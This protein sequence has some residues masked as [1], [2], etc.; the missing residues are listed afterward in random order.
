VEHLAR[1]AI[2][3]RQAEHGCL[4]QSL[5]FASPFKAVGDF[6]VSAPLLGHRARAMPG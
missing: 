1:N 6:K 5:S 4:S 3:E 2:P